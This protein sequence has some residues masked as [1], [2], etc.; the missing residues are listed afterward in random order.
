MR[1]REGGMEQGITCTCTAEVLRKFSA[2]FD[3][4]LRHL[5]YEYNTIMHYK[6]AMCGC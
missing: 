5:V 3:V 1:G 4:I 2:L 6:G